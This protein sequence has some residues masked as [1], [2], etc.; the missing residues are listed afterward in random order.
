MADPAA[1]RDPRSNYRYLVMF[2]KWVHP[3][4]WYVYGAMMLVPFSTLASLAGPWLLRHAIDEDLAKGDV[5]G[6]MTTVTLMAGVS[7]VEYGLRATQV[8]SLQ[9]VGFRSIN[10]LRASIFH[11]V[12]RLPP[13]FFDRNPTGALLTRSTNDVESLGETLGS[14]T[15]TIPMDIVQVTGILI[16]MFLLDVKL[17]LISLLA[18]PLLIVVVNFFQKKL[19]Q[20]FL[21]VRRSLAEVNAFLAEHLYGVQVVQLSNREERTY[22]EFKQR[23]Y[24]FLKASQQSNIYDASLYAVMDGMASIAVASMLWYGAGQTLQGAVSAGLLVSFVRYLQLMYEPIKELS[25]KFATLQQS[26]AALERIFSLLETEAGLPSGTRRLTNIQGKISFKDVYFAYQDGPDVLKGITF[27]VEPGHVVALVGPTGCG[28]TTVG[29]LLSRMYAGYRGSIQVDGVEISDVELESVRSM[30]GLVQQDVT[31]FKGTVDFNI[32][33]GN[34]RL[35][36]EATHQAAQ[37]VQAQPFIE[38]LPGGYQFEVRERGANLSAGQAQLISFARAMAH[39]PPI[40]VLDEATAHVD[41]VTESHIQ[42]AIDV[43][44]EQRTVIVVAHR[45]STIRRADKILVLKAGTIAEQGTHDELME[46][47]GIYADLYNKGFSPA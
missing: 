32:N 15:V 27:D 3:W 31:L 5:E 38:S 33:L 44:M 8:F 23:S 1:P 7:L 41:T 2:W 30:V 22:G 6:L 20:S 24:R 37:L 45:L 28:K 14:G 16:T 29:K 25:G 47:G 42:K 35:T 12:C 34:P 43:V 46:Q 13:T 17:T 40:L 10:A 21:E 4:R 11:H 19:R 9:F 18:A 36:E 39:N 26:L